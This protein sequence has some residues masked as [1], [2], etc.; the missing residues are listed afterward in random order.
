MESDEWRA[1]NGERMELGGGTKGEH[2]LTEFAP[3]LLSEKRRRSTKNKPAAAT[4]DRRGGR[5]RNA[6]FGLVH[7]RLPRA[8][9]MYRRQLDGTG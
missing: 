1:T 6:L 4:H 5:L 7:P 8:E 9:C 3:D 2:F